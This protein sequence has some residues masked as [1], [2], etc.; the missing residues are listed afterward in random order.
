MKLSTLLSI[1]AFALLSLFSLQAFWLYY[2]YKQHSEKI[3]ETINSIF[4]QTVEKEL[5][6]RFLE[7]NNI[8]KENLFDSNIRSTSF[9]IDYSSLENQSVVSQQIDMFQQ[10]MATYNINFNMVIGDSIFRSLFELN[11]YPFN[12]QINYIDSVG[13]IINTSGHEINNG[14]RTEVLPVING[15]KIYAVVDI[16][17]P[18]VFRNM[19][20]ILTISILIFFFIIACIIYTMRVFFNQYHLNHLRD[21]FTHA[22][23]HDMRTPLSTIHSVL[24]QFE[25]GIINED[26]EM[27]KKFCSIGIEQVLNLQN[28]VNQI[29]TLA[30]IEKKQLTLNKQAL[31]LPVM[32]KSLIDEF[33]IKTDKFVTFHT[34]YDLKNSIICADSFYMYNVISN[35][36]DNAI[37]YSNESV[38]IFIDCTVGE[39]QAFI[40]VKDN[41][42]GI[43]NNDQ[44]KLFKRFERGAEIKRKRVSGFGIGLNYVQQVVEAHG[45]TVAVISQEKV[46][47]EFII[48]LPTLINNKEE[49]IIN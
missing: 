4:T 17:A 6:Q 26:P 32:I 34:S 20:Y 12:Y 37:K 27:C 13:Q 11:H 42:L 47:S 15:E 29:L 38:E 33:S 7:F 19:L 25:K 23:T 16:T 35:L 21:N 46:G 3:K 31:N 28:T 40:S 2:S 14:F 45:G 30:Y 24:D 22:L 44:L 36:I 5:D 1:S 8:L 48:T 39:K 10:I 49:N 9:D 18:T 41:G 43:S